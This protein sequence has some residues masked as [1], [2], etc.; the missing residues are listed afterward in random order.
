MLHGD[1]STVQTSGNVFYEDGGRVL[2]TGAT[3][4]DGD[5]ENDPQLQCTN[6]IG[7]CLGCFV[8]A[9]LH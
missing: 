7:A 8:S 2:L 1:L 5:G 3:D 9:S 4:H 6:P